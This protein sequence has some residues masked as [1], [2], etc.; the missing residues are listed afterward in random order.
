MIDFRCWYCARRYAV[1]DERAGEVWSCSCERRLRIPRRSGGSSHAPT[2]LDRLIEAAIY[3]GAGA[4]LGGVLGVLVVSRM[5]FIDAFLA[6]VVIL[7]A[8][9]A[10]FLAGAVGG[11]PAINLVGRWLREREDRNRR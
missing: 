8:T 3:G 4:I 2:L 7:G 1:A 5:R 6:W 11:E 9:L 10:G